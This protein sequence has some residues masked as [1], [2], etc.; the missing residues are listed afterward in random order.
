MLRRVSPDGNLIL[1]SRS[2]PSPVSSASPETP[3]LP[4]AFFGHHKAATTFLSQFL[5]EF[6]A[7]LN[8]RHAVVA[9]PAWIR[10]NFSEFILEHNLDCLSYVNADP[11]FVADLSFHR[12][13]HIIRDPRD[14]AVSAYFSHRYSHPLTRWP[15]LVDHRR[16]LE[17]LNLEAGLLLDFGFTDSLVTDGHKVKVYQSM[18]EWN[19]NNSDILE[20]RYEDLFINLENEIKR[21]LIH[22][23]LLDP[24]DSSI[25]HEGKSTPWLKS[26]EMMSGGRQRGQTNNYHHYR[27]GM[28]GDWRQYF[29]HKHKH[30]FKDRYGSFLIRRGY[31]NS[32][33]W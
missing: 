13:I 9:N 4:A 32:Y 6:C 29:E 19:Y 17:S 20:L 5:A 18:Q 28:S 24:S 21:A 15:E 12:A 26:F 1:A 8:K 25:A 10:F 30:W 31:E 11:S 7:T 27:R 16:H 33:D 3:K 2:Y 23:C 14:I 22:L